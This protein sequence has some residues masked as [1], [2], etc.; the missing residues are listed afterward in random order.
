MSR[1][2]RDRRRHKHT[3]SRVL[4]FVLMGIILLGMAAA[5][6][7]VSVY[8]QTHF[9]PGT[10]INGMDCSRMTVKEAENRIANEAEDFIL[11]IR[12]RDGKTEQIDGAHMGYEYLSD[13]SVQA[14]KDSQNPMSWMYA[15]FHPETYSSNV[16]TSYNKE[17]LR[18]A[19]LDLDC[20][21]PEQVVEPEDAC[22]E[23]TDTSYELVKEVEGN[24]LDEEKV[25]QLLTGAVDSGKTEVDLEEAGCYLEPSLRSD[26]EALN[27]RYQTLKKYAEMS[28]TYL[29]GDQKEVLDSMTI[30]KWMTME[31]DGSVSFNWNMAADWLSDLGDQYNTIGTLQ[32]FTTSLGETIMV[33]SETYGWKIDEA[34]EINELLTVLEAGEPVE[35]EPLYLETA[36][37]RGTS[38][39]GD[40][41]VEIDYTNQRMWFYKD[42]VCLVDTPVV[43]GN[44]SQNMGS[45]TGIYCI[46][47]KERNATLKGEG[48]ETLVDFWM[49]FYGGVGIHDAKWRSEFGGVIYQT[50]GSHGCINTPWDQVQIIYENIQI[51]DPVICYNG[52]INQ[53]QGAVSVSQPQQESTAGSSSAENG[54][55]AD[56]AQTDDGSEEVILPADGAEDFGGWEDSGEIGAA[57]PTEEN[58]GD[59]VGWED[60]GEIG[61]DWPTEEWSGQVGEDGVIIIDGQ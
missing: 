34:N 5:Y 43:T 28:V 25:F 15:F 33:K 17:M 16:I 50:N 21:D 19:M 26:D 8:Y 1:S 31:E 60:S 41:Y 14:V 32:P 2:D 44:T 4:L 46:Y 11:V 40:T 24:Q 7:A 38:D 35:K 61:A 3:G 30:R 45:P 52:G 12:E 39:I 51:G 27:K 59:S 20:F 49:P 13:G 36:R 37:T 18:E 6:L 29:I 10:Y 22:I 58:A 57:W 23:E 42:G 48:Y 54:S 53:G 55:P 56:A 47:N 9:F